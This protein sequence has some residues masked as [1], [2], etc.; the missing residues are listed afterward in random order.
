MFWLYPVPF[1]MRDQKMPKHPIAFLTESV[2]EIMYHNDYLGRNSYE[3]I[4]HFYGCMGITFE[5][6]PIPQF[7]V[8]DDGTPL[9]SFVRHHPTVLAH[10]LA[11]MAC[12]FT[13][14][15][16]CFD[17]YLF[18]LERIEKHKLIVEEDMCK[19]WSGIV[20]SRDYWQQPRPATTWNLAI[21][22]DKTMYAQDWLRQWHQSNTSGDPVEFTK[23]KEAYGKMAAGNTGATDKYVIAAPPQQQP[24]L[25]EEEEE[26]EE[27]EGVSQV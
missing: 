8:V 17:L 21:E 23:L 1:L 6:S 3:A 22:I 14:L 26:E 12:R 7:R 18:L 5:R 16:D 19:L 9:Q 11:S 27:E 15:E 24:P 2:A 25:A 4:E 10:F 13:N 20:H